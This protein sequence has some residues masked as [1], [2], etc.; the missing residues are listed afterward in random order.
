MSLFESVVIF[1]TIM[2]AMRYSVCTYVKTN[3]RFPPSKD[4]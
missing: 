2:V 1:S 3:Y 4:K